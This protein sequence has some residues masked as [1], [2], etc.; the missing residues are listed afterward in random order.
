MLSRD[1][2]VSNDC[3]NYQK[4]YERFMNDYQKFMNGMSSSDTT[5]SGD[6][7]VKRTIADDYQVFRNIIP[8]SNTMLLESST[9]SGMQPRTYSRRRITF[10][11]Y[12]TRGGG[13]TCRVAAPH[14][15]ARR[16][17]G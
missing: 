10:L 4:I 14:V 16:S 13:S 8:S 15:E 2:T 3:Q 5:I 1:I 7:I 12:G 17:R 9:D 6:N 11:M